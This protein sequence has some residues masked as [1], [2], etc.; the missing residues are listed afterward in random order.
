VPKWHCN[1]TSGSA[2]QKGP[3]QFRWGEAIL[4]TPSQRTWSEGI[5]DG[6]L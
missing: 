6:Y 3:T 4:R 2:N 5:I 1:L